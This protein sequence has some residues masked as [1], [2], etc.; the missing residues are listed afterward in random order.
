MHIMHFC[1]AQAIQEGPA[2]LGQLQGRPGG[3]GDQGS[4]L[5]RSMRL[6]VPKFTEE[7][8][9]IWLFAITE[10]FSLLNT[11]VDQRLKIVGFNLEGAAARNDNGAG[12]GRGDHPPS[13][14]PISKPRPKPAPIPNGDL[15]GALHWDEMLPQARSNP[16]GDLI[17][18]SLRAQYST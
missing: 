4:L 13:P 9:E 18:A 10:Y 8:P 7:D 3:N 2:S 12:L 11:P 17:E 15:I 16:F 1:Y 5:P 6:D 14:N